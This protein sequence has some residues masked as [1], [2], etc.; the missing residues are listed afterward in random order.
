MLPITASDANLRCRP[1]R[2][3]QRSSS[4]PAASVASPHSVVPH[5]SSGVDTENLKSRKPIKSLTTVLR[6][7]KLDS[8]IE[9]KDFITNF[10]FLGRNTSPSTPQF[11]DAMAACPGPQLQTKTT[12]YE[13]ITNA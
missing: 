6:Q 11:C 8:N 5:R 4:P 7:M 2:P 10:K 9:N 1:L 3:P 13:L 12:F